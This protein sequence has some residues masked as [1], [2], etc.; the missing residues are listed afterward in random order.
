MLTPVK[1]SS[2]TNLLLHFSLSDIYM[3]VA[4]QSAAVDRQFVKLQ[5]IIEKEM[6]Y[7]GELL[8]VLGM[9]DTLFATMTRK[10]PTSLDEAQP[11]VL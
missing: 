4:G 3:P 6:D 10:K 7:Q 8:V 1:L 11:D 5:N 9:M 2:S